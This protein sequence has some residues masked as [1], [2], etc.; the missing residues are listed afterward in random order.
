M[1]IPLPRLLGFS[2]FIA[3][4]FFGATQEAHATLLSY[5]N[6]NNTSV[7]YL[8]GN[9]SLGSFS[10]S[11]AAYGETYTQ[12]NNST[13]GTLGSN[14][15]NSTAFNGSA[16]KIDFSN[17]AT[18][19]TSI[20]NGK[21]SS[22]YTAQGQTS[23]VVGGYG[24]FADDTTNRAA[25]D[26]TTGGSMIIMN[27]S[28][29]EL[30]KYVVFSLSSLGYNTLS[31]TYATRISSGATGT[32]TWTYSTDG[33]NFSSLTSITSITQASFGLQTLNLSTLSSNALDNQSAFYLRMTIGTGSSGSYSFDNIQLTG[34]ATAVPEPSTYALLGGAGALG[35]AFFIRRK[36]R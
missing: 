4:S 2:S 27:P 33:T 22:A 12:T 15:A 21:T 10:T 19:G 28:G 14:T 16:I 35:L 34:T 7:G 1:K 20:I 17:L 23:T 9:G 3:A 26:S 24:T 32:E 25:S 36:R 8:S 6:F 29:T 18:A 13:A 5:W 11:A 30:G 31:L